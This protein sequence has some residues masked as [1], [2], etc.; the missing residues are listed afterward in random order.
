MPQYF[1]TLV[2]WLPLTQIFYPL[3]NLILTLSTKTLVFIIAKAYV[4]FAGQH[5]SQDNTG[6]SILK[7]RINCRIE[8]KVVL[9]GW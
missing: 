4:E 1:W 8:N 7:S 3:I 5:Q 9:A 2:E 6:E